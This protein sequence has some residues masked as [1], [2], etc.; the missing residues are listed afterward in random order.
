[1][2]LFNANAVQS[3]EMAGLLLA[4]DLL[5]QSAALQTLLE[6]A[7][8]TEAESLIVVGPNEPPFNGESYAV[9]EL[10]NRL[11]WAQLYPQ[12]EGSLLVSKSLGV[13]GRPEIEGIFLLHVRRQVRQSEYQN[14][15]GRNDAWK[16]FTDQTSAMCE[17][18]A[19]LLDESVT[20]ATLRGSQIKR[21]AVPLYNN[22][23]D[24]ETQG[25]FIFADYQINWGDNTHQQ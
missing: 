13:G 25:I 15:S 6:A 3:E 19:R 24:H 14:I 20:N 4:Q 11:A 9:D 8:S 2:G 12:R 5:S 7:N 23:A 17:D 1:M 16:Y 18:F 22:H 10:E 21:V